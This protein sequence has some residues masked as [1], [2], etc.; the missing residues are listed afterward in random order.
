M[1]GSTLKALTP[2]ALEDGT[3]TLD[4]RFGCGKRVIGS[5]ILPRHATKPASAAKAVIDGARPY[6]TH[7]ISR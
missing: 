1:T 5:E 4:Q 6:Q 2:T 7:G 3:I